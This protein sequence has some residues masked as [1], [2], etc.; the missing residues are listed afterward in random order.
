MVAQ[1]TEDSCPSCDDCNEENEANGETEEKQKEKEEKDETTNNRS[2]GLS[3]DYSRLITNK[4]RDAIYFFSDIAHE[5][6]SP[7]P[8]V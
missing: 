6:E 2:E 3:Y 4:F 5:L 1:Q 7:P 8:E